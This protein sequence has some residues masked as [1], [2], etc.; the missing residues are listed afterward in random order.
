VL[1]QV[2][3]R[4]DDHHG[5]VGRHAHGDH[6]FGYLFAKPH[7]R[8]EPVRH[9]IG[10]A[11]ING[12]F[13]GD[14]GIVRQKR[15]QRRG[16]DRLGRVLDGRDARGGTAAIMPLAPMKEEDAPNAEMRE[17]WEYYHTP[18]AECATAPGFATLRSLNQIITYDAYH[19]ADVYLTQPI[20][21]VVGSVAGS[22]WMSDD[23]LALAASTD[24]TMHILEGANHMSLYDG[25]PYVEE[26]VSLLSPFSREKLAGEAVRQAAE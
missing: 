8:I 13:D 19:M 25:K 2:V 14:I 11:V 17:A 20:L 1:A 9:H 22:K 10:E 23:L 5:Y 6:V 12:Q 3:G 18:R 4:A 15:L 24:K 21:S 26:A 7:A 16:D